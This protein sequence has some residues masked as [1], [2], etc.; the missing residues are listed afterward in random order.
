MWIKV[1][2]WDNFQNGWFNLFSL[3]YISTFIYFFKYETIVRSSALSFGHSYSDP[4]SVRLVHSDVSDQN[5]FHSTIDEP[6]RGVEK[7]GG[8][9]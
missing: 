1:D 6:L 3:F 9:N 7:S 8:P 4:G 5:L 2:K